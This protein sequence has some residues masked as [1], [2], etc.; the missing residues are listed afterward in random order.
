MATIEQ[1][2]IIESKIK[3][4]EINKRWRMN[5]P[6]KYLESA[7]RYRESHHEQVL[8]CTRKWYR[9][10]LKLQ[11]HLISD[12]IPFIQ[13]GYEELML[14]TTKIFHRL[15]EFLE[16]SLT[17]NMYNLKDS[18]HHILCGNTM[19]FFDRHNA[20]F[21]DNRW[22]YRDEWLLPSVILRRVMEYNSTQ[23]Y[24]NARYFR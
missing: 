22:L 13:I 9:E 18:E 11:Q 6:L 17:E 4:R 21:Y 16:I 8:E 19:R 10:N 1:S 7:K 12:D 20:I 15:C 23:V 5:N 24:S 2:Q 3:H 14:N